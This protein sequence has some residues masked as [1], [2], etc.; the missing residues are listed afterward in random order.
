MENRILNF[1]TGILRIKVNKYGDELLLN[2]ADSSVFNKFAALYDNV[3]NIADDAN[4]EV[5][6]LKQKYKGLDSGDSAE[7]INLDAIVEITNANIKY[8]KMIMDELDEVFGEGFTQKVYR[9]NY[10]LDADF[11]PDE[12]SLIELIEA[13]IPVMEDAYGERIK[14]TKSKYSATK[15]G[16]HTKSKEDLIA[17]H[18]KK[19]AAD[20]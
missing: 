11:V 8:I 14:K 16:K 1:N 4:N 7:D 15:K 5:E 10:E 12:L 3:Q 13:L 20:E 18:R 6:R 9:E 19:N 17:E 2:S